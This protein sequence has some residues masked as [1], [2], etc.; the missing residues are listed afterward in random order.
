[1]KAT[2]KAFYS[3]IL[4]ALNIM[5]VHGDEV[6]YDEL[7]GACD[8][9]ELVQAA[10]ADDLFEFAGLHTR[11]YAQHCVHRTSDGRYRFVALSKSKKLPV[12]VIGTTSAVTR[13]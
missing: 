11:K 10:V 2:T 4:T 7:V 12:K 3:G 1:M 9:S 6:Q 5:D 13:R 8:L